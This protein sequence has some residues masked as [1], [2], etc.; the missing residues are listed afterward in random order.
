MK[1]LVIVNTKGGATKTTLCK[2]LLQLLPNSRAIDLDPQGSLTT[3]SKITKTLKP[4]KFSD[5][6]NIYP[7]DYIIIDTPSYLSEE[8]KGVLRSADQILIPTRIGELDLLALAGIIPLIRKLKKEKDTYIIF[9]AVPINKTKALE[10]SRSYFF[11]NFKDIYKAKTEL[12]QYESFRKVGSQPLFGHA[13][14]QIKNLIKEL[15]L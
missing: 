6:K 5:I 4:I 15:Q 8:L 13:E 7:L 10:K 14:S 9:S 12:G 1:Q 11:K 3:I 2:S